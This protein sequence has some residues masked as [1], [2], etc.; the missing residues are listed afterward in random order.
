MS[1]VDAQLA[2]ESRLYNNFSTCPVKYE[3]VDY[4]PQPGVRY[5]EIYVVD[6]DNRR[7]DI[8]TNNP[9]HRTFG[10][11]SVN[12]YTEKF[13]GSKPGRTLADEIAAVY[14]DTSFSG[15]TCKSPLVRNVG[16]VGDWFVVN[17]RC[18]FFRDE[19]H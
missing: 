8:G 9:L 6:S 14:R 2:I 19:V 12:I 18:E 3:N 10:F 17:M 7:A 1:F 13:V 16:E 11:I 5:A 15:I 4:N